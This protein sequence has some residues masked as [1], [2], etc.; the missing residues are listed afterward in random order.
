LLLLQLD[1][2]EA[3]IERGAY[4][5]AQSCEVLGIESFQGI[6]DSE[7]AGEECSFDLGASCAQAKV[8]ALINPVGRP[9]WHPVDLPK[10]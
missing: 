6:G 2:G 4:S 10:E 8:E 5:G 1:R 7:D 9:L 3:M